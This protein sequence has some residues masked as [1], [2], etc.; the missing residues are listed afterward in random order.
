MNYQINTNNGL[1]Y[2]SYYF[3]ML[4]SIGFD[5]PDQEIDPEKRYKIISY[6]VRI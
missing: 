6:S 5:A 2:I 3:L 4:L 1:R